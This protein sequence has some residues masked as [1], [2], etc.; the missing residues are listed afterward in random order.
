M[1]RLQQ[2]NDNRS[3]FMI[4]IFGHPVLVKWATHTIQ[5]YTLFKSPLNCDRG[6]DRDHGSGGHDSH[7][8]A[9]ISRNRHAHL[10][11]L[12]HSLH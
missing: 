11:L 9:N 8:L 7:G 2:T 4:I 10:E 5:M 6:S 12:N 3:G 1:D